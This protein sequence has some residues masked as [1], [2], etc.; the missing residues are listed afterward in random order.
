MQW[1]IANFARIRASRSISHPGEIR[2]RPEIL[3]RD[4]S[5]GNS[6]ISYIVYIAA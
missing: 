4:W 5:A 6:Y 2:S 3:V 1:Y